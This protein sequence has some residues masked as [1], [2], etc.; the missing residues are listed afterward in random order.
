MCHKALRT[1]TLMPPVGTSPETWKLPC[2]QAPYFVTA[3]TLLRKYLASVE[4]L[5]CTS[6]VLPMQERC[7]LLSVHPT[8]T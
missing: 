1:S 6:W 5:L 4:G 8:S 7:Q 3:R 2:V